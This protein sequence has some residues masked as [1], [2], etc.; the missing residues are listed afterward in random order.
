MTVNH[1]T[2]NFKQANFFSSG[3]IQRESRSEIDLHF[4]IGNAN[5]LF[6]LDFDFML[7]LYVALK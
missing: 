4:E 6:H 7:N 5:Y 1:W 3:F 2:E